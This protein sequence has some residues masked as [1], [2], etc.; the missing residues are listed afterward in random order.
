MWKQIREE[1]SFQN[2]IFFFNWNAGNHEEKRS[3]G[4]NKS[5]MKYCI[6]DL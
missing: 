2:W 1:T 6:I 5:Q 4:K 3:A